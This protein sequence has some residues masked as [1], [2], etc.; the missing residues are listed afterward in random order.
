VVDT[1]EH[2]RAAREPATP[3]GG[4]GIS[5]IS[6]FG[7]RVEGL[8]VEAL[9]QLLKLVDGGQ[10]FSVKGVVSEANPYSSLQRGKL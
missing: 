3:A 5:V 7:L 4:G 6:P 9:A 10:K 1:I 8:T 2:P